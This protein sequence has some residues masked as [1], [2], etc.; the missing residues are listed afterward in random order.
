M[1]YTAIVL[2]TES[3]ETL[4]SWTAENHGIPDDFL[5]KGHHMTIDLKP[6]DKSMGRDFHEQ[7]HEMRVIRFGRLDGIMAVEVQTAVPSKNER[8]H[9][10]LCHATTVK[11][12]M[13][14]QIVEW[15]DVEP[16]TLYGTVKECD[17]P[18]VNT[19]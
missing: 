3:H 11:P 17:A 19:K 5:I 2:E 7:R 4:M 6:V 12:M 15:V 1:P 18:K 16:F 10:T 13:S 9:I 14:N 8:K